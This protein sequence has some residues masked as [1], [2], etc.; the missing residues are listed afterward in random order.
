MLRSSYERHI[1][2][3]DKLSEKALRPLAL[4]SIRSQIKV[5]ILV[6]NS[7]TICSL[8]AAIRHLSVIAELVMPS[9]SR[10][11]LNVHH[12]HISL[13]YGGLIAA[14]SFA[15]I[16]TEKVRVILGALSTEMMHI[17]GKVG[18]HAGNRRGSQTSVSDRKF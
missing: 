7:K 1:C 3:K 10:F 2:S 12:I 11:V 5:I 14:A 13:P 4:S 6:E 9:P 18:Q 8:Q 16:G 15:K 17:F